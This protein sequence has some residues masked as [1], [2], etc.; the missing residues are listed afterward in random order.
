LHTTVLPYDHAGLAFY[1]DIADY[2]DEI[3]PL[4]RRRV[5][6][7]LRHLP[8]PPAVPSVV[9]LGCASGAL[10]LALAERGVTVTGL[11]LDGTMIE[12]ARRQAAGMPATFAAADMLHVGRYVPASTVDVAL[13]FGN[14]LP[15]LAGPPAVAGLAAAVH[16]AL[17]PGG[18]FIVQL[19][20]YDDILAERSPGLPT[21]DTEILRF[22][23]RYDY[24]PDGRISFAA[25]LTV[26]ATGRQTA[27]A[28]TLYPLRRDELAAAMDR[29]GFDPVEFLADYDETPWTPDGASTI[30]RA[31]RRV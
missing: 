2:Y 31:W 16:T 14:T 19:I 22:Q 3:F 25:T 17:R 10:A 5:D 27:N 18:C 9:D 13:C 11:D 15:H 20:N 28:V 24:L 8:P 7:V 12:R 21:V 26:K 30:V 1:D 23:R 4:P 6:F 29:G